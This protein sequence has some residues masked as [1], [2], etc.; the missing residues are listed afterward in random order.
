M[1]LRNPERR[2][3]P[4]DLHHVG[5]VHGDEHDVGFAAFTSERYVV[6]FVSPFWYAFSIAIVPPRLVNESRN[7]CASPVE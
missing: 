4:G 5:V 7:D 2:A 1:D 3:L 6:K